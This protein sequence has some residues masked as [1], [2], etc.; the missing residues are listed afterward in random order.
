[1]TVWIVLLFGRV[2][3]RPQGIFSPCHPVNMSASDGF[4]EAETALYGDPRR[5][6]RRRAA[7]RSGE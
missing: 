5:L 4:R 1:M 2:L 7:L 3:D 6:A